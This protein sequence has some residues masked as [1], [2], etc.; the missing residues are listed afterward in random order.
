MNI[1][2]FLELWHGDTSRDMKIKKFDFSGLKQFCQDP[3][4]MLVQ[5]R[6]IR[7]LYK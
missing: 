5:E 4:E 2:I 6:Y 7:I 1:L 3:G